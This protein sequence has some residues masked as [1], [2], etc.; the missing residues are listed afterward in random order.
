MVADAADQPSDFQFLYADDAPFKAKIEAIATRIYG[1]DGVD[2]TPAAEA[3]LKQFTK[4]GYGSFSI[5]MA[6]THLSL[7]HDADRCRAARRASAC[8]SATCA[9]TPARASSC[10]CSARCARCPGL[11][12]SPAGFNID[13]DADGKIVGLFWRPAAVR[14]AV[15]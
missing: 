7:S 5:C 4:Q 3:K 11:G 1:A 10:R 14:S 13:I 12:A 6:K 15:L 2:Y 8:R 9:P